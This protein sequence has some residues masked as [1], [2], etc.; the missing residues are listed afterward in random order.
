MKIS[1]QNDAMDVD[2]TYPSR[3]E[4][5]ELEHKNTVLENSLKECSQERDALKIA[6]D[7]REDQVKQSEESLRALRTE[8]NKYLEIN[9]NLTAQLEGFIDK[10]KNY[11]DEIRYLK[12][13]LESLSTENKRLKEVQIDYETICNENN[14]L[15]DQLSSL[16]DNNSNEINKLKAQLESENE[17]LKKVQNDYEAENND[18]KDQLSSF[19]TDNKKLRNGQ[20]NGSNEIRDLK[21]QLKSLS[22]E[23]ERLNKAQTDLSTTLRTESANLKKVTNDYEVM[24]GEHDKLR[25]QLENEKLKNK[26]SNSK[27]NTH[28]PIY[29]ENSNLK[30]QN[31]E[32]KK[33]LSALRSEKEVLTN[34]LA[35]L[36]AENKKLKD[37]IS[38]S[39]KSP[40]NYSAENNKLKDQLKQLEDKLK[41]KSKNDQLSTDIRVKNGEISNF[42][43]KS[44]EL[45]EII[46]IQK[47]N[48]EYVEEIK[49]LK[50]LLQRKEKEKQELIEKNI[51][52]KKEASQYQSALGT[53]TNYRRDDDDKNHSVQLK[54]DIEELQNKLKNY[55][56][57]LKGDFEIDFKAVNNLM[58]K[59]NIKT[60]VTPKQPNKPLIKAVLHHYI[61]KT[62]TKDIRKYFKQNLK[63]GSIMHLE[64]EIA[65]K[66]KDLENKLV[67]FYKTRSGD[68]TITQ[69]ASIKVRQE[70][71]IALGNRGF[72]DVLSGENY[73]SHGYIMLKT[74]EL[75]REMNKY[76]TIKDVNKRNY[77]EKLATDLIREFIRIFQF[78]L[79]VQEPSAQM[80]WI[81]T[82]SSIDPSI[83]EG[84]WDKDDIDNLEVEICSFPMI[85]RD[86][87]DA[88]KRK[89]YTHAQVFIKRKKFITK[90]IDYLTFKKAKVL[91]EL[92]SDDDSYNAVD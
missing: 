73:T 16:R 18:L 35:E 12:E 70:V 2:E 87:E 31:K 17:K 10:Q 81:K 48:D 72:S 64:K 42:Q 79:K 32:N 75:N 1:D 78:R 47:K 74:A 54:K 60:K 63:E 22:S 14:T 3:E 89:I 68:D 13:R 49:D 26:N 45:E 25:I 24:C 56:T 36:V 46:Q 58:G 20:K 59:Y 7:K 69:A 9:N 38:T 29:T 66:A 53:M 90:G 65:T 67:C 30:V 44:N 76:R 62:I 37:K 57:T 85:G 92:E 61:I 55:V 8:H 5:Q 41:E 50:N 4:F 27:Q 52:L 15:N 77:V 39:S 34:Q 82:E 40:D 11:S 28:S 91:L 51:N 88:E 80:R 83:M 71:N 43:N 6:L 86:L 23:C 84:N 33:T 21:A 19:R